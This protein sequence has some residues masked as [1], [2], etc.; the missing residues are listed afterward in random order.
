MEFEYSPWLIGLALVLGAVYALV[1]YSKDSPWSKQTNIGL[2]TIRF[3]LASIISFLLIGP[4]VHSLINNTERPVIALAIDNSE[5]IALVSD[6][7]GLTTLRSNLVE[8]SK[9]LDDLGWDTNLITLGGE[10]NSI[11]EVQFTE[12]RSDLT[13]LMRRVRQEHEG[14]N[15]AGVFL[16]SDGIYNSGYS[17][18]LISGLTPAYTVGIGDTTVLQDL[19]IID[20]RHNKTVFQGNS[21]P[22]EVDVRN[23]GIT[24]NRIS[25]AVY[26]NG[27]IKDS[28]STAID[29]SKRI[30]T[31]RFILE[32]EESG[33]QGYVIQITP[34]EAEFTR[35][36]NRASFY[37]DVIEGKQKILIVAG[38]IHPDIKALKQGIEQNEHFEVDLAK[39]GERDTDYDLIIF[40]QYPGWSV[41][42]SDFNQLVKSTT[43][44]KLVVVGLATDV[45]WL[46]ANG[47]IDFKL[48]NRK[49]DFVT[50]Y[51]TN[52]FT[53]FSI[54]PE[55]SD[56]LPKNPPVSVA[57]GTLGVGA[58]DNVMLRQQVGAVKTAKP[59]LYFKNSDPKIG[60]LLAENFWRWRLD[61]YRLEGTHDKFNEL[62]TKT[63]QF[64][65]SK[66]DNRQ[67]KMYPVKDEFEVGE[68]VLLNAETYNELFEPVF[69]NEVTL[70]IRQEGAANSSTFRFTPLPGSTQFNATD[71]EEGVYNFTAEVTLE[72][73]KHT[74][75]GQFVIKKLDLE[76]VDL[77]ADFKV[78]RSIAEKSQGKFYK[79]D[80]LDEFTDDLS[81]INAP[82]IIHSREK[83]QSLLNFYWVMLALLLLASVEWFLR[84]F[85]GSY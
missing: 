83:E 6:S 4:M 23:T 75:A 21:F 5:S 52:E 31:H 24:S 45:N 15:L 19:S 66:P 13:G 73:K 22:V 77:T 34:N 49:G 50:A 55:L 9:Q 35:V 30:I 63:V 74:A 32:A 7:I 84:K 72:T 65:A 62:I 44:P 3:S 47:V 85:Y 42:R 25:I 68:P 57:Y 14:L 17:P 41:K 18:D 53:A 29:P 82:S 27:V 26:Q 46:K 76:A 11:D 54:S 71:L 20:I 28:Y 56:W 2:A 10:V 8:L 51:L 40:Y 37:F 67:F 16:L 36:N 38:T 1:M 48:I 64:L 39:G 70:R 43:T 80:Q 79:V 61:E 12:S 81:A 60:F 78:L 69:G 33:K 59:L 58:D